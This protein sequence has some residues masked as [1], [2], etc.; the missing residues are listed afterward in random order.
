MEG[1]PISAQPTQH[2]I[3]LDQILDRLVSVELVAGIIARTR[4]D[5]E[6]HFPVIETEIAYRPRG[7]ALRA[8]THH[9]ER[10]NDR[11]GFHGGSH[12]LSPLN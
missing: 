2:G 6:L 8:S 3:M 7:F 5:R 4:S 10:E 11:P 12:R 1:S 9:S